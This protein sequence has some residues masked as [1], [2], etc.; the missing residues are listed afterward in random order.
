[1]C[2]WLDTQ[3][4]EEREDWNAQ[5]ERLIYWDAFNE[6]LY[7]EEQEIVCGV[8]KKKNQVLCANPTTKMSIWN[9]KFNNTSKTTA[10][11][12]GRDKTKQKYKD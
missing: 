7:Q 6:Q 2:E 9:T 5:L 3:T 11:S 4:E 8:E 12:G 1:M 10:K